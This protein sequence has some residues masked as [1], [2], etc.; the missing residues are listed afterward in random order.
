MSR[1]KFQFETFCKINK[2]LEQLSS[3]RYFRTYDRCMVTLRFSCTIIT[4]VRS[5]AL[6]VLQTMYL[7]LNKG[8]KIKYLE[9]LTLD[10]VRSSMYWFGPTLREL[11]SLGLLIYCVQFY[12]PSIF[13]AWKYFRRD[14]IERYTKCGP[15]PF[16]DDPQLGR[17]FLENSFDTYLDKLIES[18]KYC[19]QQ[20]FSEYMIDTE[21]DR[22]TRRL[23]LIKPTKLNNEDTQD[24]RG[25]CKQLTASMREQREY[26]ETLKRNKWILWPTERTEESRR[27]FMIFWLIMTIWGFSTGSVLGHSFI[28]YVHRAAAYR[29]N[30]RCAGKANLTDSCTLSAIERLSL[31]TDHL[32][33]NEFVM[34]LVAPQLS[35]LVL[36]LNVMGML[37]RLVKTI[38]TLRMRILS[39]NCWSR[40][41]TRELG[42]QLN[43]EYDREMLN[44]Y[45]HFRLCALELRIGTDYSMLHADR[46]A[47]VV[48]ISALTTCASM[49]E[50]EAE[51]MHLFIYLAM[52][53]YITANIVLIFCANGHACCERA[54]KEIWS[55]IASTVKRVPET[56]APTDGYTMIGGSS[57]HHSQDDDDKDQPVAQL[58]PD[59]ITYHSAKIW[60]RLVDNQESRLI[61]GG[62]QLFDR[63]AL[64]YDAML[65]INYWAITLYILFVTGQ[66]QLW[67]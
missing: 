23:S 61:L 39:Y 12:C 29:I 13:I 57:L 27:P 43:L 41:T 15:R 56:H 40:R 65:R 63:L 2:K 54:N 36:Y 51:H 14:R 58:V 33:V 19:T 32:F 10:D 60:Y 37:S 44:T 7:R 50:L 66:T 4:M 16:L 62:C 64:T 20:Y 1:A 9:W 59:C 3:S 24:S 6:M 11:G 5:F 42:P 46:L 53:T 8:G 45:M 48:G 31:M 26:L 34:S 25:Y 35:I 18:N 52:F 21:N 28:L 17:R 55:L 30:A 49:P 22:A 47:L 67:R 38:K